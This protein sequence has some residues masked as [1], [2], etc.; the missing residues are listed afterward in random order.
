MHQPHIDIMNWKHNQGLLAYWFSWSFKILQRSFQ[1]KLKKG[2]VL[3]QTLTRAKTSKLLEEGLDDRDYRSF[4]FHCLPI[5]IC[6]LQEKQQKL[7]T[8]S[9]ALVDGQGTA[10]PIASMIFLLW[11]RLSFEATSFLHK[12][13]ERDS[14]TSTLQVVRQDRISRCLSPTRNHY[15]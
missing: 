7:C 10:E 15:L 9:N 8:E 13:T 2:Q 1:P 4:N 3:Q 14:Y 12:W 6:C 5:I 11:V